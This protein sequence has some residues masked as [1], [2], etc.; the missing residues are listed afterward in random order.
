MTGGT[1]GPGVREDRE[2][3]ADDIKYQRA[4]AAGHS[5]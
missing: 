1:W 2:T 5:Q 3:H 4:L